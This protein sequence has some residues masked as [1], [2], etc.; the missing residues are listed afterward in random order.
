MKFSDLT[1]NEMETM[2]ALLN[3]FH[4][5]DYGFSVVSVTDL[6]KKYEFDIKQLRGVVSSLIK[7]GIV[8]VHEYDPGYYAKKSQRVQQILH[9]TDEGYKIIGLGH[10]I[11]EG[12]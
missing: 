11:P 6:A 12:I 10:L 8:Y 9:L 1:Q 4:D 7:K 3:E 5:Q 2:A